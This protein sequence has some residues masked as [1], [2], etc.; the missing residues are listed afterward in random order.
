[1]LR[2]ASDADQE[3]HTDPPGE[4]SDDY[5]D[6]GNPEDR[7]ALSGDGAARRSAYIWVCV[8]PPAA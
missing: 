2:S 4:G 3:Q 6:A 8:D 7:V 5:D 1:V